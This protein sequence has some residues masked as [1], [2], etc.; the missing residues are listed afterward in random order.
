MLIFA[1]CAQLINLSAKS[2]GDD[3]DLTKNRGNTILGGKQ[4]GKTDWR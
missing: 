4:G 2:F 1:N 3:L